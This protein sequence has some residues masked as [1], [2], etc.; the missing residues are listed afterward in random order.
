M[1]QHVTETVV[2][3]G[4]VMEIVAGYWQTKMLIAAVELGVF[5]RLSRCSATS[6]QIAGDLGLAP[7]A[8]NDLLAGLTHLGLLTCESKVFANT[9]VAEAFLVPGRPA[10]LGGYLRFCDRELNPSWDGLAASLRTGKPQNPAAVAGNP[11]DLL[12]QDAERTDGFLDSMDLLA[13]PIGQAFGDFDWSPYTSFVDV[14]GARGHFAHQ[15]VTVHPGLKATVFDL[16]PLRAAFDRYMERIGVP[17]GA[18]TFEGGDF[19]RDPLPSADVIVLGHVLHNWGVEDRIH[20]L[21]KVHAA[22]NP[23]GAVLVYDPM[24]G[25]D[26]PAMYAALA[27]LTMSVWSRGGHEYSVPDAHDWLRKVGFRPETAQLPGLHDDVLVIGHKDR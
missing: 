6:S 21:R 3:P 11:Y 13:S 14:G 22:L 7:M 9:P 16:P 24:K 10:Y 8:T 23:G 15:V 20:L 17:H 18:I 19:F 26:L 27:G 4:P 1:N 25:G 5:E 12:Y 2:H